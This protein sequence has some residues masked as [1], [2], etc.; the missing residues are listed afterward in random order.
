MSTKIKALEQ[1][2]Q[3]AILAKLRKFGGL[4]IK[5]HDIVTKGLPDIIGCYNG[6]FIAIEV[7]RKGEK[8][9]ALQGYVLSKVKEAGG[10][11]YCFDESKHADSLIQELKMYD[12][13]PDRL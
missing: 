4:W 7:K 2:V 8:P 1:S 9:T 13:I 11:A 10:L 12:S 6:K 5:V 3:K